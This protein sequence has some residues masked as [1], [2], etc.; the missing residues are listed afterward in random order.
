METSRR[1]RQP[2]CGAPISALYLSNSILSTGSPSG[3]L[4]PGLLGVRARQGNVAT[5]V[6]AARLCSDQSQAVHPGGESPGGERWMRRDPPPRGGTA[7]C[8]WRRRRG[9]RPRTCALL[10]QPHTLFGGSP[11]PTGDGFL[12]S[13]KNHAAGRCFG[14]H[15][16]RDR[17]PRRSTSTRTKPGAEP[18]VSCWNGGMLFHLLVH[19]VAHDPRHQRRRRSATT[20][21]R[22]S[23]AA[24]PGV[25]T[26]SI[27][28]LKIRPLT[29]MPAS[30]W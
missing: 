22:P 23:S 14:P 4:L 27:V 2:D 28:A 30:R 9:R 20:P 1:V 5:D 21:P 3:G 6:G 12:M 10:T 29:R 8:A 25:G 24:A 11:S 26:T 17:T 13:P 16:H 18:R 19:G 15:P 7:H